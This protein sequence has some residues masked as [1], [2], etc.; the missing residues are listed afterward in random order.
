MD[1]H[2]IRRCNDPLW[3]IRLGNI[4]HWNSYLQSSGLRD[5]RLLDGCFGGLGSF[6]GGDWCFFRLR[7]QHRFDFWLWLR[8]VQAFD[9]LPFAF[10]QRLNIGTGVLG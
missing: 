3:D 9:F 6:H 5:N 4:R 7:R 1:F 2:F 10:I 8:F